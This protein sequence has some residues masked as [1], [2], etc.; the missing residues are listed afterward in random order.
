MASIEKLIG[1]AAQKHP[2][3]PDL[4]SMTDEQLL[5][6]FPEVFDIERKLIDEGAL[7]VVKDETSEDDE[8]ETEEATLN[9]E[10]EVVTTRKK[11]SKAPG[12]TAAEKQRAKME[13]LKAE[14][15]AQ[16]KASEE[17][18]KTL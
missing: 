3:L 5:A 2:D 18:L 4:E 11:R 17:F 16:Q 15:L 9:A 12:L 7:K 8:L 14:L 13:K 6:A 1:H 10:G